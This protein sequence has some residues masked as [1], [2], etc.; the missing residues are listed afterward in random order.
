[1]K[2][3]FFFNPRF[4]FFLLYLHSNN[5]YLSSIS[6]CDKSVRELQSTLYTLHSCEQ[7]NILI[8]S[9]IR[10]SSWGTCI[11]VLIPFS[12]KMQ[13]KIALSSYPSPPGCLVLWDNIILEKLLPNI[14]SCLVLFLRISSNCTFFIKLKTMECIDPPSYKPYFLFGYSLRFAV[15]IWVQ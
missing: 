10:G 3:F 2:S 13:K 8:R 6:M 14:N 1:M 12:S 15:S 9:G 5:I 4:E 11:F 7:V